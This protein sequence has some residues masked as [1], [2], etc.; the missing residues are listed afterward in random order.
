MKKAEQE[1]GIRMVS[2][3]PSEISAPLPYEDANKNVEGD[4]EIVTGL[5]SPGSPPYQ[6]MMTPSSDLY[7]KPSLDVFEDPMRSSSIIS[8]THGNSMVYSADS[9]P[10]SQ[11][12]YSNSDQAI[13]GNGLTPGCSPQQQ[14]IS[15]QHVQ[16]LVNMNMM[17]DANSQ[18]F[19]ATPGNDQ[20]ELAND[21]H[22]EEDDE[23]NDALEKI[24]E[25]EDD[26][27]VDSVYDALYD[28][29]RRQ[30]KT[31]GEELVNEKKSQVEKEDGYHD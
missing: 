24:W 21:V 31:P 8:I 9:M 27:D 1:Q 12:N 14:H 19:G 17:A 20:D 29:K 22:Y 4:E 11:M 15:S 25:A 7:S 26:E 6:Q 5:P 18:D 23:A 28:P 30:S 13:M 16:Q 2:M 10:V 3:S